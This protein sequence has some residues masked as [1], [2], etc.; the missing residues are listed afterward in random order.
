MG[1]GERPCSGRSRLAI[2][3]IKVGDDIIVGCDEQACLDSFG[4]GRGHFKRLGQRCI[5]ERVGRSSI[6]TIAKVVQPD[7]GFFGGCAHDGI[8]AGPVVVVITQ[9]PNKRDTQN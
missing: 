2:D 5:T 1:V 6:G 4:L 3:Q 7:S 9:K 8:L